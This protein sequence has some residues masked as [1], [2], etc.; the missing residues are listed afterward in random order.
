MLAAQVRLA[1]GG[2]LDR[3]VVQEVEENS[4]VLR[5]EMPER[6]LVRADPAV[7]V[8]IG[9]EVVD[10]T[11][12]AGDDELLQLAHCRLEENCVA[13]RQD[14]IA[15]LGLVD[16][17]LRFLAAE[18]DRLLDEDVLV[19]LQ[20]SL[21][22]V[23]A[24]RCRRR[25]DDGVDAV[26]GQDVAEAR[27]PA[28]SRESRAVGHADVRAPVA[29]PTDLCA[30]QL[31]EGAGESRAALAEPHEGDANRRPH[32][33]ILPDS[34]TPSSVRQ[35]SVAQVNAPLTRHQAAS[36]DREIERNEG[37]GR[38]RPRLGCRARSIDGEQRL[39]DRRG[40][41][42]EADAETEDH[43]VDPGSA[44]VCSVQGA[45]RRRAG[46]AMPA[47]ISPPQPSRNPTVRRTARRKSAASA[48]ACRWVRLGSSAAASPWKT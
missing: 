20:R 39:R 34:A 3:L 45:H 4:D 5:T 14:P 48:V 30:G 24:I 19:G 46:S 1:A 32:D 31:V 8:P 37:C 29:E 17:G 27:G 42:V 18:C 7:L 16:E 38:D 23:E 36:R 22:E 28:R 40:G 2:D 11:E 26:V 25:D 10:V 15:C 41:E 12:R 47:A 43:E 35:T 9:V 33:R 44:E 13:H 6:V 21:G